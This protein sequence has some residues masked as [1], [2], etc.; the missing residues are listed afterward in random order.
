MT[1][2]SDD[3]IQLLPEYVIGRELGRGGSGV[4]WEARHVALDR[5]VAVKQLDP[6]A[7]V[8]PDQAERF[9]REAQLLARLVHPHVVTVYDYREAEDL[10]L[11]V[12]EYMPGGTLADRADGMPTSTAIAAV[13]AA[14]TGLHH[15]HRQD[16]LHRDVKPENLLFDARG[17]LKVTDFGIART[18]N[19]QT[20]PR[21][22]RSGVFFG[23]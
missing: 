6:H 22:T 17:V 12:M 9:R 10:R 16:V 13:M 7:L 21:L 23:T 15:V 20:G 8:D 11:L 5:V 1:Q 4:V 19:E 2:A 14:A 18:D 3:L